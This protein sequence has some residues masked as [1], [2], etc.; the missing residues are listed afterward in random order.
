MDYQQEF[1]PW[2]LNLP[3]LHPV[4][5]DGIYH[6]NAFPSPLKTCFFSLSSIPTSVSATIIGIFFVSSLYLHPLL[7]PSS[8]YQEV[9]FVLS[10][11]HLRGLT[12]F[13]LYFPLP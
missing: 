8:G 9:L 13:H 7:L 1:S 6:T 5:L 3:I 10:S 4:S 2:L 12:P 11:R